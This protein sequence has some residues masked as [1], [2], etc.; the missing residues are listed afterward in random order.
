MHE[1]Q[2]PFGRRSSQSRCPALNND[3]LRPSLSSTHCG[4]LPRS[5]D[6]RPRR[7]LH[8]SQRA[9]ASAVPRVGASPCPSTPPAPDPPY[10]ASVCVRRPLPLFTSSHSASGTPSPLQ[11]RLHE[12]RCS[13]GAVLGA[14]SIRAAVTELRTNNVLFS[15]LLAP[16][17]APRRAK[18]HLVL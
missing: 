3:R 6:G 11:R 16:S 14:R 7:E 17:P 9:C 15:T 5:T 8:A 13:C 2:R 4:T 1:P 12:H 18:H 10:C